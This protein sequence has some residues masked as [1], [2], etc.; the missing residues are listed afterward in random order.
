MKSVDTDTLIIPSPVAETI[1]RCSQGGV[2]EGVG[3]QPVESHTC[4]NSG[5]RAVTKIK[6]N[7]FTV[8]PYTL[9]PVWY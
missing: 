2:T 3:H 8:G 5:M 4:Q 6:T 1:I 7:S 9:S